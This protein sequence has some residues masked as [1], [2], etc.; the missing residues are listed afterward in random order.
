[1]WKKETKMVIGYNGPTYVA[2]WSGKHDKNSAASDIEDFQALLF[3]DKFKEACLKD[4]VLKPMLFVPVDGGQDEAP[5][6]TMTLEAWVK[7]F[8]EYDLDIALI[9]TLSRNW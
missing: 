3:L 6:S 8:K 2:I 9:F 7:I 4:G 5:K 1:M